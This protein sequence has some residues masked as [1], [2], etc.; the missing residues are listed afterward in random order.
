MRVYEI[1]VYQTTRPYPI[2]GYVATYGDT[3]V[4]RD[5]H[6]EVVNVIYEPWEFGAYNRVEIGARG[7]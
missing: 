5:I 4:I 2:L 6:A 3:A 7:V 1:E